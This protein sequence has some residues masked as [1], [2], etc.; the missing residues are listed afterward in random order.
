MG[1]LAPHPPIAANSH[2]SVDLT[3]KR[4]GAIESNLL[5]PIPSNSHTHYLN[6]LTLRGGGEVGKRPGVLSGT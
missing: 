3:N 1:I 4:S 5:Y 2:Y 6:Y